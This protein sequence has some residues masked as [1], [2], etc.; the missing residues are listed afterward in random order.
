MTVSMFD[1]YLMRMP[2]VRNM[3]IMDGSQSA[4]YAQATSQSRVSL[5]NSWSQ[6]ISR[7]T[8]MMT[9]L[10][11]PDLRR[12]LITWNGEA[13][14]ISTLRQQFRKHFGRRAVQ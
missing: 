13:I 14:S 6:T 7:V 3:K 2:A 11:R 4:I 9:L 8:H 12:S 5:W 1:S 10:D